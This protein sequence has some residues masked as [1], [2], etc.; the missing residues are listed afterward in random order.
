MLLALQ[1]GAPGRLVFRDPSI[2]PSIPSNPTKADHGRP[3]QSQVQ[4]YQ[5]ER[6]W[7][8]VHEN[9]RGVSYISDAVFWITL[10]AHLSTFVRVL[11]KRTSII[12]LD[13]QGVSKKTLF[14]EIGTP[15]GPKTIHRVGD[16][17]KMLSNTLYW[18]DVPIYPFSYHLW[19]VSPKLWTKI[20]TI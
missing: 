16:H 4:V 12:Y 3:R 14:F 9:I 15:S 5:G 17:S 11:S 13:I 1:S 19:M 18:S 20:W 10:T 7:L 8:K 2:H 6:R